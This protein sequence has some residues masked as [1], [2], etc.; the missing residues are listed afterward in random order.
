MNVLRPSAL[1]AL[2]RRQQAHLERL[3]WLSSL[4][5]GD[6]V[7]LTC[8]GAYRTKTVERVRVGR[9]AYTGALYVDGHPRRDVRG[10]KWERHGKGWLWLRID[11]V[12]VE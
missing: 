2:E 9:N 8:D 5:T 11:P 10:G 3:K 4:K 12:E 6:V 7:M 1:E